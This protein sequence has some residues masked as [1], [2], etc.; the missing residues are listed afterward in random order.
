MENGAENGDKT[1]TTSHAADILAS[2]KCLVAW[3]EESHPHGRSLLAHIE[4]GLATP[5]TYH[6]YD[7]S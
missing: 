7:V 3:Q 6:I 1:R 5:G 4:Y 2:M